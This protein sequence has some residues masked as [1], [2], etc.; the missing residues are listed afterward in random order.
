MVFKGKSLQNLDRY[1][2]AISA[3]DKSLGI[4][5]NNALSWFAKGEAL[6]NSGKYE[7]AL[8]SLEKGLELDP[9]NN[10]FKNL[11]DV[12]LEEIRK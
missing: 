12:I 4:D 10:Q 6:S 1:D 11:R 3:F 2:E 8:I 5:P 7:E 9:D